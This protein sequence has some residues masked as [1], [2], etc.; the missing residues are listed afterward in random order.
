MF[1]TLRAGVIGATLPLALGATTGGAQL[2]VST[3]LT[4]PPITV[5]DNVP[6]PFGDLSAAVD[7][8]G[9][10]FPGPSARPGA[11]GTVSSPQS[12]DPPGAVTVRAI[13]FAGPP[14]C[15]PP[16]EF[17]W[18][19]GGTGAM[20]IAGGPGTTS[21]SISARHTIDLL[22]SQ[23]SVSGGG[24]GFFY[25]PS[26]EGFAELTLN[27]VLPVPFVIG[28]VSAS[29]NPLTAGWVVPFRLPTNARL[30]ELAGPTVVEASLQFTITGP[31][32][33][34]FSSSVADYTLTPVPE[35]ST[36]GLVA[37]GLALLGAAR[38][39]RRSR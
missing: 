26:P 23:Y 25:F 12:G 10:C 35:P 28:S 27:A 24:D 11:G 34:Y 18:R 1:T 7:T 36:L 9:F 17:F 2:T 6:G 30:F 32:A 3:D 38:H 29:G 22:P 21:G 4:V 31:A 8:I 39:R 33:I 15:D 37:L 14:G 16:A 5:T 13:R 19:Y 20:W